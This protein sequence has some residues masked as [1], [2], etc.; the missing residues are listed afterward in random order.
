MYQGAVFKARKIIQIKSK[1]KNATQLYRRT[2]GG[3]R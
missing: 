2:A 1:I 3:G